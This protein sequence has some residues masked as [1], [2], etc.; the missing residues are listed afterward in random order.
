MFIETKYINHPLFQEI[1]RLIQ[2]PNFQE[3][4]K[5]MG[6]YDVADMGLRLM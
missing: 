3:E 1:I 5:L 4:V 2:S 6:G